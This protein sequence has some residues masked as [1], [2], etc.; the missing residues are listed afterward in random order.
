[1]E[2]ATSESNHC[3]DILIQAQYHVTRARRIDEEEKA[4]KRKQEEERVAFKKRQEE[5]RLRR[6][7]E[8]RIRSEQLL[9][10]RKLY[11]E[12]TKNLI[13]TIDTSAQ[14]D[15]RKKGK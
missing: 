6:E 3:R 8:E 1:M 11:V 10:K 14:E 13:S 9:A 15:K 7:E 2:C 4:M 12:K 5:E